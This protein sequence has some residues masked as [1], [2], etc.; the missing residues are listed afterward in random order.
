MMSHRKDFENQN[1]SFKIHGK[2]IY[3]VCY[4]CSGP[5]GII[6]YS[7]WMEPPKN[8]RNSL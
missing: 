1:F 5:E 7:K 6:H 4:A 8:T 2:P 3:S